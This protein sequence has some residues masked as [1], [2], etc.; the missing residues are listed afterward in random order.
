LVQAQTSA[1]EK[2][3]RDLDA[4]WSAAAA[5]KNVD[6]TVSYYS[7]DA[8]VLAPN[9]PTATTKD[10]IRKIWSD[11]LTSPGATIGWKVVKVEVAKSGDLACV[12]GNYEFSMNDA[13]G[14]P[15]NDKGKYVELWEKKGGAW[16]CGVD[17]WNSDLPAPGGAAAENK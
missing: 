1:V 12:T 17:I 9:T 14:K 15:M 6:K 13:A 11:F 8:M 5:S 3:L 7:D 4:Q 2:N 16:K 10:A